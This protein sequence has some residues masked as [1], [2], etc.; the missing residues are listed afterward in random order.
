MYVDVSSILLLAVSWGTSNPTT[1]SPQITQP[2]QSII[3]SNPT[4]SQFV[5]YYLRVFYVRY[6]QSQCVRENLNVR[7]Y[8]RIFFMN[9]LQTNSQFSHSAFVFRSLLNITAPVWN[10]TIYGKIHFTNL[11]L[12]QHV[13]HNRK[14]GPQSTHYEW[15][16]R[17]AGHLPP[18]ILDNRNPHQILKFISFESVH[19]R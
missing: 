1:P 8:L 9:L 11:T 17:D 2:S 6:K 12:D 5:F 13:T 19:C 10:N 14:N 16:S 7:A 4:K 3:C 18:F 15:L